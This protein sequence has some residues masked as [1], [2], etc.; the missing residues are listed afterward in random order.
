M[1]KIIVFSGLDGAG[2]STQIDLLLTEFHKR[3]RFV[4]CIWSRGGY[5]P[6]FNAIKNLARRLSGRRGPSIR[7]VLALGLPQ[8]PPQRRHGL[9]GVY[10]SLPGRPGDHLVDHARPA[11]LGPAALRLRQGRRPG[12]GVHL[13][14]PQPQV[15]PVPA[16]QRR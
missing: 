5:T 13:E 16:I 1:S 2:K 3:E 4:T 10:T 8:R 11:R 12:P 14:L 7:P 9:F 15:P 6:I